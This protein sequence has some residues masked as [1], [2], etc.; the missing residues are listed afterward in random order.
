MPSR[1]MPSPRLDLDPNCRKR[2]SRSARPRLQTPHGLGSRAS[3]SN[4]I[5]RLHA[6]PE[7]RIPNI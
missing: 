2:A 6:E 7:A 1:R 3:Q 4:V 5:A